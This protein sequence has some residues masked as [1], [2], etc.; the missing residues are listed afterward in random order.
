MKGIIEVLDKS[1][2]VSVV[3]SVK[4]LGRLI[5]LAAIPQVKILKRTPNQDFKKKLNYDTHY[6]KRHN[7]FH[8]DNDKEESKSCIFLS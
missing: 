2:K 7:R 1:P 4:Q 6:G 3:K 5:N 8:E